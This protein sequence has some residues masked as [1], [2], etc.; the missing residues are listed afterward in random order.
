MESTATPEINCAEACIN[1]CV[2]GENCPNREYLQ[3]AS[4]FIH[5]TP[6]D[7]ILQIAEDSVQKRFLASIERDRLNLPHQPE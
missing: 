7:Q 6:I 1:G 2:L 4:K 3:A 5:D